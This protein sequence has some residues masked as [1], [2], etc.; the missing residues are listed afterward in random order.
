VSNKCYQD[1][2][3]TDEEHIEDIMYTSHMTF[4]DEEEAQQFEVRA[5]LDRRIGRGGRVEYLTE[6]MYPNEVGSLMCYFQAC[7]EN[8]MRFSP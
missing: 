5:I 2:L 7:L 3:F 6:Y 4:G 1:T 8:K